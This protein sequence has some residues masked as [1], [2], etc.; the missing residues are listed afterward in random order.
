LKILKCKSKFLS[1]TSYLKF[2]PSPFQKVSHWVPIYEDIIG[3]WII[4]H[5][6]IKPHYNMSNIIERQTWGANRDLQRNVFVRLMN[7]LCCANQTLLWPKILTNYLDDILLCSKTWL[8][9]FVC[10]YVWVQ[11]LMTTSLS[12]LKIQRTTSRTWMQTKAHD[13]KWYILK[14]HDIKKYDERVI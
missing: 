9:H 13:H 1:W 6:F 11:K 8:T 10:P 14:D 2:R 5:F 12:H 3:M 4:M 7:A